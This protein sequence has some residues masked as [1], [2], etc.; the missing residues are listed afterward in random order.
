MDITRLKDIW[1][2]TDTDAYALGAVTGTMA[3]ALKTMGK[4]DTMQA[5]QAMA[6]DIW[7]TRNTTKIPAAG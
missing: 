4:A 6:E 3:I 5:A 1:F 7:A 2:G